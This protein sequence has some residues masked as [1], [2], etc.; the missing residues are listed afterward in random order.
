MSALSFEISMSL[1]AF[2]AGPDQRE[3]DP[4]GRGGEQL[5]EWVVRLAAWRERH[6]LEGGE[7]DASTE[8]VE[9]SHEDVGAVLM[10]RNM[11][12][13]RGSWEEHPWDGWWGDDP[14]FHMPVFVVT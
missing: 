8:A 1:D 14:P 9:H 2:I 6:G 13:G 12:G 5:H 7:T 4:L 10:G 11:F 3:R